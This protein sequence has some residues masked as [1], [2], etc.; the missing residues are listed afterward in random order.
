MNNQPGNTAFRAQVYDALLWLV[1][2]KEVL[3]PDWSKNEATL[4]LLCETTFRGGFIFTL[5]KGEKRRMFL[6]S[7]VIKRHS[8]AHTESEESTSLPDA[9]YFLRLC[10]ARWRY[11]LLWVVST[12]SS[13]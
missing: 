7:D 10:L 4:Y 2:K 6:A 5:Q 3:F 11:K 13:P 8:G 12:I 9:K 1:E